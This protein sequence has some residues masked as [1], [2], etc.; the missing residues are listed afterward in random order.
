MELQGK[1]KEI[2]I[3]I[4]DSIVIYVR[5]REKLSFYDVKVTVEYTMTKLDPVTPAMVLAIAFILLI[6]AVNALAFI[7]DAC[8]RKKKKKT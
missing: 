6:W 2:D 3:G 4:P 7:Y 5:G 8:C 1:K